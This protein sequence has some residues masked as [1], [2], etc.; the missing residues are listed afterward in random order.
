MLKEIYRRIVERRDAIRHC[1]K[2]ESSFVE[3]EGYANISVSQDKTGASRFYGDGSVRRIV[4]DDKDGDVRISY[5]LF[6]PRHTE[7]SYPLPGDKS[8]LTYDYWG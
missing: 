5:G 6:D 4:F 8:G 2:N 1:D 7:K 3:K